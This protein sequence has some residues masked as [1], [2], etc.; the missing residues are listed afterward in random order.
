MEGILVRII[1]SKV[2]RGRL[3]NKVVP[4]TSVLSQTA[5]EV[6]CKDLNRHVG[7]LREKEIETVMPRSK[8]LEK[9][10]EGP[11]KVKVLRGENAGRIGIVQ[12]LDKKRDKVSILIDFIE[13]VSCS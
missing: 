12:H 4:V 13:L 6:Y 11:T 9:K 3:Y 7:D 1:S 10:E 5:F 2:H 8:H